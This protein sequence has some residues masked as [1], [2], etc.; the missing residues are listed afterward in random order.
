MS[1]LADR[2][3]PGVV[4]RIITGND[5]ER[6]VLDLLREL[7]PRYVSEVERQTGR[8]PGQ[9]APPKG[10]IVAS[11]FAKW[12]EDQMPVV[13]ATSPGL[14]DRPRRGG[15]GRTIAR[16]AISA[17]VINS[18]VNIDKTRSNTLDYVA[19]IRTL[20]AQEQSLG[21]LALGVEWIGED[22]IPPFP[23]GHT[24]SLFGA[25]ALFTVTIDDVV[26]YGWGPG[27]PWGPPPKPAAPTDP[28]LWP[29]VKVAKAGVAQ[30][31][32]PRELSLAPTPQEED[33]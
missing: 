20:V 13:V 3:D 32:P 14:V 8:T 15:D 23:F 21:G 27:G 22:Y 19:A 11:Q 18:A 7:L 4:G 10:Y 9:L 17:G 16:W 30:P 6:A 33:R 29:Q 25:Q 24:R 31:V 26:S 12:P 2:R 1:A 28:M 5:L